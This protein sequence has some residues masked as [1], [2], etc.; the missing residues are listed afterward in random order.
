MVNSF[1]TRLA[2]RPREFEVRLVG[3]LNPPF[4]LSWVQSALQSFDSMVDSFRTR[5]AC[6]PRELERQLFGRLIPCFGWAKCTLRLECYIG[7]SS[8][9]SL[10]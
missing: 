7:C 3:R 8:V 4:S 5:L 9:M 6:R 1:R 10:P 2:G